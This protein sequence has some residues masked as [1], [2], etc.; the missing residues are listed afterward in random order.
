MADKFTLE[1]SEQQG[2]FHLNNGTHPKNTNGY[3]SI[4]EDITYEEYE[5]FRDMIKGRKIT[6]AYLYKQATIFLSKK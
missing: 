6:L 1:Y 2:C 5:K 3:K 4:L